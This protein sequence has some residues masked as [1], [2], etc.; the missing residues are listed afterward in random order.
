MP[1]DRA[2]ICNTC[3]EMREE[4]IPMKAYLDGVP[5]CVKCLAD[6]NKEGSP[7]EDDM[8]AV[9]GAASAVIATA[10]RAN[11]MTGEVVPAVRDAKDMV[12]V[13]SNVLCGVIDGSID[14]KQANAITQIGNAALRAIELQWK[15][16]KVT[17]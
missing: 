14:P 12:S 3:Y 11:P 13:F 7:S 6:V 5:L 2:T 16:T 1:N 8:E 4:Q 15:M 9:D 17:K 10:K